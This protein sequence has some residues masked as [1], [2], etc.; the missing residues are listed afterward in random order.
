MLYC[1]ASC[2][3]CPG[4]RASNKLRTNP[5][6]I[7]GIYT[8]SG[9][10][11][12]V[13]VRFGATIFSLFF[14]L[15]LVNGEL[16]QNASRANQANQE[17]EL[18]EDEEGG[19]GENNDCDG[20]VDSSVFVI[21]AH[22]PAAQDEEDE[23]Q[24]EGEEGDEAIAN[25]SLFLFSGLLLLAPLAKPG[26]APEASVDHGQNENGETHLLGLV[27]IVTIFT[28]VFRPLIITAWNEES[29]YTSSENTNKIAQAINN[30]T[31]NSKASN[32]QS[33][34]LFSHL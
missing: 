21:L 17:D 6:P 31:K 22:D 10:S 3:S 32:A 12:R 7:F 2:T 29:Q 4:T 30:A 27:N 9:Y 19:K 28:L 5:V 25:T 24:Q 16:H 34:T 33:S 23:F 18:E 8:T 26:E 15:G 13:S 14:L 11:F 1:L 20:V